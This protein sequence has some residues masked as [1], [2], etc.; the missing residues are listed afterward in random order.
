MSTS[1]ITAKLNQYSSCEQSIMLYNH[2]WVKDSLKVQDR[3][4]DLNVTECN[5]IIHVVSMPHRY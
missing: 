5:E 3:L 2:T 1:G 4:M